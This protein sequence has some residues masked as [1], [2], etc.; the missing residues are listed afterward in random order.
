MNTIY[1]EVT[2][3]LHL[4]CGH[5]IRRTLYCWDLDSATR[6]QKT[7][8]FASAQLC[9]P[10]SDAYEE[11]CRIREEERRKKEDEAYLE[12]RKKMLESGP[13]ERAREEVKQLVLSGEPPLDAVELATGDPWLRVE[14]YERVRGWYLDRAIYGVKG[15]DPGA[16]PRP[17]Q[18]THGSRTGPTDATGPT[19]LTPAAVRAIVRISR[20]PMTRRSC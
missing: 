14:V 7:I 9:E 1:E 13:L 4:A 12:H 5:S 2:L 19:L 8:A 20:T 15:P 18:G 3:N 16:G 10:C 6:A 17:N 11:E